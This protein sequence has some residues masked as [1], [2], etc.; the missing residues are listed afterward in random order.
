MKLSS[1]NTPAEQRYVWLDLPTIAEETG[2]APLLVVAS[3]EASDA[4]RW[5]RKR[6]LASFVDF[7]VEPR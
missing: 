2:S 1:R 7:H 5:P 6:P 3:G 4:N